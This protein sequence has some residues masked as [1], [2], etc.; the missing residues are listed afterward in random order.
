MHIKGKKHLAKMKTAGNPSQAVQVEN[1]AE[2]VVTNTS[3][4]DATNTS[5]ANATNTYWTDVTDPSSPAKT[6]A[7]SF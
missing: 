1:N 3:S 4:A 6:T 5:S 2:T 7:T